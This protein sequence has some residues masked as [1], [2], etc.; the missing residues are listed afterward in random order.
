MEAGFLFSINTIKASYKIVE[1]SLATIKPIWLLKDRRKLG[2]IK[3]GSFRINNIKHEKQLTNKLL[4]V[5]LFYTFVTT[6]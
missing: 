2:F 4:K 3:N 1:S 6:N 5:K